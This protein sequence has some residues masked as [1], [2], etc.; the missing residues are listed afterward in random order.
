[1]RRSAIALLLLAGAL[2]LTVGPAQADLP[3]A[4]ECHFVGHT[5]VFQGDANQ[6]GHVAACV[7]VAGV[8]VVFLHLT[9]DPADGENQCGEVWVNDQ[10][11]HDTDPADD[12]DPASNDYTAGDC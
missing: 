12:P 4:D 10:K 5:G 9:P 1:M 3:E 2:T 8:Q 7:A 6:P 11:I